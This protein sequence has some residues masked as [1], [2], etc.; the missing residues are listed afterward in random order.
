MDITI[1]VDHKKAVAQLNDDAERQIPFALA[2][3][4]NETIKDVQTSERVNLRRK[5][6]LRR[7]EWADRSVKITKFASKR[8]PSATIGIHPPGAGGDERSDILGKFET[9]TVKEAHHGRVAIPI[10]AKRTKRDIVRAN[11][12]PRAIIA[13]GK[14]FVIE[15]TKNPAVQLIVRT[16]GR[17]RRRVLET[18]YLLVKRVRLTRK[19]EFRERAEQAVDRSW[20][21]NM[22]KALAEA[23][24][25]AR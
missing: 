21:T 19:L 1:K 5:F 14:A 13:S 6:T 16:I 10:A 12:R 18:L 4:I 20:V 23:L 2:K 9:D 15:H 24:R 3:G 17:G 11:Q 7:P 25:T 8:D 22:R